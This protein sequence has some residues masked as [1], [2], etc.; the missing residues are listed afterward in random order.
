MMFSKSLMTRLVTYGRPTAFH[1]SLTRRVS[2]QMMAWKNYA[3][4]STT[5]SNCSSEK[6]EREEGTI[7]DETIEEFKK[8]FYMNS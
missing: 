3:A 8:K 2:F 5:T 4:F 1:P 6:K 7:S